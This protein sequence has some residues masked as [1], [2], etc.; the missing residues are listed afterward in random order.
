MSEDETSIPRLN[1]QFGAW[2]SRGFQAFGEQWQNWLV[3]M[4]IAA[5]ISLAA[6]A[7]LV[8][9]LFLVLGPLS[10]GLHYCGLRA[11]RR[12]PVDQR[13][14]RRGWETAGRS[15]IASIGL[16]FLHFVPAMVLYGLFAG[17]FF[18]MMM[19]GVIVP[20][21]GRA[22]RPAGAPGFGMRFEDFTKA[23]K[24]EPPVR[25]EMAIA[26][27]EAASPTDGSP[28]ETNASEQEPKPALNPA[29][30]P[31]AEEDLPP[32][33]DIPIV[34]P[35]NRALTDPLAE[36]DDDHGANQAVP[37]AGPPAF[38]GP[39]RPGAEELQ[40]IGTM[41]VMYGLMLL[42]GLLMF[43]WTIWFGMRT[44]Y[45]MPLIADRGCSFVEALTESWRLTRTRPWELLLTY[46]LALVIS[47]LGAYFCYVGL[48][49]TMPIYYTIIAA[50]YEAHALPQFTP[51]AEEWPTT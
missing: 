41:I 24:P 32:A 42:G 33:I 44:M 36:D 29:A 10:C 30:H 1:V 5:A 47:G 18:A 51:E 22:M 35:K 2:L 28:A 14:L 21:G 8:L 38:R 4:V 3:P 20:P 43:L 6:T 34:E 26:G 16:N 25:P 31:A 46:F 12:E 15:M 7:C 40:F 23:D 19:S 27:A 50:A 39:G 9:P 17:A 48:L 45:V 13:A 49:V 11:V 37:A